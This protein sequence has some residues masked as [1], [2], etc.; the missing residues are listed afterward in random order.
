LY[1]LIS[2]SKS[3]LLKQSVENLWK[4][5]ELNYVSFIGTNWGK[6]IARLNGMRVTLLL[7]V[8]CVK[9]RNRE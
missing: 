4:K 5:L 6:I 7:E 8:G 3:I 1:D 2:I 9:G